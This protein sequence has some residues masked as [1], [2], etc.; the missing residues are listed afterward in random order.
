MTA[1]VTA[2]P[3]SRSM[4]LVMVDE[5]KRM[6]YPSGIIGLRG[7]PDAAISE[8]VQHD[9]QTVR[10]RPAGSA[11]AVR[12]ALTEHRDGEWLV[13]VT[14]RDDRDL[15]AGIL[16]HLVWQRLRS[17]DPW[18]AVRHRFSA[19]GIDPKLTNQRESRELATALLSAAP[20]GGWP[21]A[22][23]GVLTRSHALGAVS[24]THL[25]LAPEN[26]DLLGVL[27]WSLHAD[28]VTALAA[29]RA[30]YGDRLA[31]ATLE[32]IAS[33][34]EPASVPVLAL[35][36]GGELADLVPL[37]VAMHVLTDDTLSV[38]ERHAAELAAA[39]LEHR[40]GGSGRRRR[41]CARG[42]PRRRCSW[43]NGPSTRRTRPVWDACW[44]VPRRCSRVFRLSTWRGI[45]S[46]CRPGGGRGWPSWA[47]RWPP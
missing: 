14:D 2:T 42:A 15:G 13:I 8:E 33:R 6:D 30:T 19:T 34:A 16:A 27:R 24:R 10:I 1:T 45:R 43:P 47:P 17:P 23:A 29:L 46:C 37:G 44:T 36:R 11:L 40:W 35:L 32:W 5:A 38:A 31:D 12:L 3:V 21:A 41:R 28:S 25:G 26:T 4:V 9:G 18:E 7:K 22:P 20:P 39:R